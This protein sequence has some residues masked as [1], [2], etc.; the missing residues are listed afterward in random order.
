[1]KLMTSDMRKMRVEM[2][3]SFKWNAGGLIE[4]I[5]FADNK[6]LSQK[7]FKKYYEA[8]VFELELFGSK[9]K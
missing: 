4:A 6:R 8:E 3:V 7:L 1:M 9:G 5:V 2:G